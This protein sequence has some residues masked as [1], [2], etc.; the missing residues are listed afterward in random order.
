[1]IRFDYPYFGK[2][3]LYDIPNNI[4][5]FLK[6]ETPECSIAAISEDDVEMYSSLNETCLMLDHPN[7][8]P[9]PHCMKEDNK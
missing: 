4:L 7:F 3:Y 1:M 5:H 9:C 8:K 2:K 6:N